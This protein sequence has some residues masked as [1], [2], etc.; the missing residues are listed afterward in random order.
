MKHFIRIGPTA[1]PLLDWHG[2]HHQH[3]KRSGVG[4]PF[5]LWRPG[6]VALLALWQLGRGTGPSPLLGAPKA[7]RLLEEGASSG[8]LALRKRERFQ[9]FGVQERGAPWPFGAWKRGV[10]PALWRLGG[11]GSAPWRLGQ[12]ERPRWGKIVRPTC[13]LAPGRGGAT[14]PATLQIS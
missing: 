2:E 11:G 7:L 12:G 6:G 14:L 5:A 13:P 4:R 8:P 1:K 3:F 9:P 10:P